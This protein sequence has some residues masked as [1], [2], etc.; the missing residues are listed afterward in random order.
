MTEAYGAIFVLNVDMYRSGKRSY[1]SASKPP[2]SRRSRWSERLT[3]QAYSLFW[4]A[5]KYSIGYDNELHNS[6]RLSH[7]HAQTPCE[8][9][10]ALRIRQAGPGT[11]LVLPATR[12]RSR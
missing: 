10:L 3:S 2:P 6:D 11:L 4:S 12:C 8:E 7:F 1:S 5:S 9:Y